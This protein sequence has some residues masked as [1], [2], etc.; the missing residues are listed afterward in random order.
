[1]SRQHEGGSA[2][3]IDEEVV[4]LHPSTVT[5]RLTEYVPAE[6]HVT[7]GFSAVL[8]AGDPLA[9]DQEYVALETVG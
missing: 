1:M 4:E 5:V 7:D 8:E 6:A 9:N 3:I 2:T